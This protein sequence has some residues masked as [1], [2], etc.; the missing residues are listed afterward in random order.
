MD[1]GLH[2]KIF[3]SFLGVKFKGHNCSPKGKNNKL[4]P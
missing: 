4:F 3:K 1:F 2:R